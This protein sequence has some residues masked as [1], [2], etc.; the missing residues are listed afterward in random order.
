MFSLQFL[1]ALNE[2]GDL[3]TVS[4]QFVI[5]P[6]LVPLVGAMVALLLRR[7][8]SLQA[9]WTLATMLVALAISV[10]VLL[11][12][13]RNGRP[14]VFDSGGWPA[15]FGITIVGDMLSATF[16]VM[17][18]L[19]MVAGILYA[20]GS[21]DTA[22][23]YPTFFPLFLL[24][25][26]GLTGA[27]FTGDLFNMFVFAELL[28]ISGTVLTAISDDRFG[29]EA[30]YKYFYI[31]LLASFFMLLS[32]GCL[33]AS[34]GTLNMADLADRIAVRD[35]QP[36][37]LPAI[38]FLMATFMIKSAVFPMHFWQPDFHAA[39][40][41]AVSAMLSSV[42]VKLGVYGFLRMTTLLFIEQ[43]PIIRLIL[44]I[45]GITGII[46]G[47]LSAI[48]TNNVKR[49][50]AY[51]TVAQVGF[52]LVGIGWGT[53]L[54]ITAAIVFSVNHSLIKAALLMLAGYIASRAPVKSAAFGVVT[55]IGRF[56][57]LSG[58]LFFFGIL[59]LAGIP[60]TNGFISKLLLFGSGIEGAEFVSLL[61]IGLASILT[62]IYTIR[63]F[64]RIWWQKPAEDVQIKASGDHLLAPS[65][66]VGLILL[67]GLWSEPLIKTAEQTSLWLADP[68]AYI[69]AVLGG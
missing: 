50:L 15:P 9:G 10:M 24:L 34:Y 47:G 29:T 17:V 48:G 64:Q 11:E 38:G 55:G 26:T 58:L 27:I 65:L 7:R 57:P 16:V 45:L 54:S 44:L 23:G 61:I 39:S 49:M 1:L 62:L 4:N 20:I 25:A 68:M 8:R 2:M 51:S 42:V 22:V 28:V 18:Q 56:L 21:K 69:Q 40:P 59:A 53:T 36:L 31:S 3:L 5:L 37:L 46:F 19:V 32:I 6:V 33:Y 52:I 60:P 41:T 67:L 14:L 66:L 35:L 63:A 30:A 12:V 13:S 43:A